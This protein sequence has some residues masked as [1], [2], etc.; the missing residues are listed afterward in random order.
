MRAFAVLVFA[1]GSSSAADVISVKGFRDRP[2]QVTFVPIRDDN[3]I[4]LRQY[5][6]CNSGQVD[7]C[8][9]IERGIYKMPEVSNVRIIDEETRY[10]VV[11]YLTDTTIEISWSR[12]TNYW[13]DNPDDNFKFDDEVGALLQGKLTDERLQALWKS[14]EA[15]PFTD[16]EIQPRH[17]EERRQMWRMGIQSIG[18]VLVEVATDE[19]FGNY[20]RASLVEK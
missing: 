17:S 18:D 12:T 5:T 2:A 3:T 4:G 15:L 13:K 1:F 16:A 9:V 8:V 10:R 7:S 20:F 19:Q 14:L 11:G 6:I